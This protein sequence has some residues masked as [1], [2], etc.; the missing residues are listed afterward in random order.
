MMLWAGRFG[1]RSG[2]NGSV[3]RCVAD[4]DVC[5]LSRFRGLSDSVVFVAKILHSR[6]SEKGSPLRFL[7]YAVRDSG[8]GGVCTRGGS[9]RAG[10][11]T[12]CLVPGVARAIP[13]VLV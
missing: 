12:G 9:D 4:T 2:V 7:K 6:L 11:G 8:E 3:S 10:P 1:G 13:Y 5:L